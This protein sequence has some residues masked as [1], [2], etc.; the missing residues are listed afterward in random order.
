MCSLSFHH[1]DK[2][3][4]I[5]QLKEGKT[6]LGSWFQKLQSSE[7]VLLLWACGDIM[8]EVH[9]GGLFTKRWPECK[10]KGRGE[11]KEKKEEE[12]EEKKEKEKERCRLVPISP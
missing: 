4:E 1:C 5:N 7:M 10:C 12:E 8:G 3:P 2:I 11:E 6:Y 9:G